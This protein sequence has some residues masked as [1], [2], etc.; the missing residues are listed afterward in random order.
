MSRIDDSGQGPAPLSSQDKKMYEQ[1][2]KQAADLFQRSLNEY[3]SA[4]EM[5]KKEAFKD[6]MGQ[7][8][9]ILNEAARGLKRSDLS[10]QNQKIS[11]DFLAYQDHETADS[12]NQL[13]NDLK[14]AKKT[15]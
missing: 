14:Q 4:D 9:Q 8:M 12:K 15:V 10:T 7:A 13:V 6:V 1:E 5:N 11:Q 2:Y 3:E